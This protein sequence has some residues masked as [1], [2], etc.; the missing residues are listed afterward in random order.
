MKNI[1]QFHHIVIQFEDGIMEQ[2]TLSEAKDLSRCCVDFPHFARTYFQIDTT[3]NLDDFN[4]F[5]DLRTFEPN[6]QEF[7]V[8]L[9]WYALFEMHKC[10]VIMANTLTEAKHILCEVAL[11]MSSLPLHLQCDKTEQLKLSMRLDNGNKIHCVACNGCSLRGQSVSLAMFFNTKQ[12]N[13]KNLQ[14]MLNGF[15][16]V[17]CASHN[18]KLILL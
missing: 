7:K 12:A 1:V 4:H 5:T 16:P 10:I 6:I 8:L 14:D 13:P 9:V 17:I 15:L 18:S 11:M 2:F 3:L